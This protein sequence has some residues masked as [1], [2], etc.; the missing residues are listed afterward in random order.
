MR[1]LLERQ[2]EQVFS[3]N[4]SAG[5]RPV[6]LQLACQ[7]ELPA[8]LNLARRER[9]HVHDYTKDSTWLTIRERETLLCTSARFG[10]QDDWGEI[11]ALY[12]G[13][14]VAAEQESL[15]G[16]MACSRKVFALERVLTWIFDGMGNRQ[17]NVQRAFAAVTSNPVGY[18]PALS[19]VSKNIQ[20]IRNL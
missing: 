3:S 7:Y 20:L 1:I 8:C 13:S 9:S 15:L 11:E 14:N 5:H 16:A 6:I 10:T 2:Y 4:A 17:H 12:K 18:Q 19:F